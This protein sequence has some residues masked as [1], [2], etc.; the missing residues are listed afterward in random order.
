MP[1][2]S[3][4]RQRFALALVAVVVV[5]AVASAPH[6]ANAGISTTIVDIPRTIFQGIDRAAK[7]IAKAF[8]INGD[9]AFKNSAQIFTNRL[10]KEV[11]TQLA[12]VGP[13]QKP[14]FLTKPKSF[15]KTVTNA[16]AGDFIDSFSRGVTGETGPGLPLSGARGR[17]LISRLLRAQ[18]GSVINGVA[19]QCK[20]DCDKSFST[21]NIDIETFVAM[22]DSEFKEYTSASFRN[23]HEWNVIVISR[24]IDGPG[25]TASVAE[26]TPTDTVP[27]MNIDYATPYYGSTPPY[28]VVPGHKLSDTTTANDCLQAQRQAL[29]NEQAASSTEVQQCLSSC[30]ARGKAET[31]AVKGLTGTDFFEAF[32]TMDAQNAPAAL[33]NAL[34]NDKSDIGQFLNAAGTLT[35]VIQE[36]VQGEQTNL[37]PNNLPVTTRVSEEVKTPSQA[38]SQLFGIPY[39]GE[40]GQFTYTGTSVADILKGIASFINSPVGRALTNYFKSKCGLNPDVCK[41]PS[42]ARSTVGQ[43]VFGNGAPT[44]VAGAKL[45]YAGFGKPNIITGDPGRNEIS[46][47]EQLAGTGLIDA[48]FRQAIEETMTVQEAVDKNLIDKQKTFGFDKNGVEPADGY[49]YRSLQ[50]LRKYRVTPVGWELAARYNLNFDHRDLSLGYLLDRFSMCG[51]DDTHRVCARGAKAD[52]SCKLFSDGTNDCGQ[53]EN[54]VGVT[55]GASPYCGLIDPNWV[56]KAPQTYCKRQGAGEEIIAKEFVCDQNNVDKTTGLEIR[57]GQNCTTDRSDPSYATSCHDLDAPVCDPSVTNHDIGRWIIQRNTDTC[58]D[59]QSCIAENDDGTCQAFGYCVQERQQFKFDGTQCTAENNSC[60]T[61]TNPLG[62]D[63]AYLSNTLDGRNCSPDNAGCTEYCAAG[64]YDAETQTCNGYCS[65]DSTKSCTSSAQCGVGTCIKQT[66]NFTAKIQSCDKSQIGCHQYLRT[67]EGANI[68]ADGGFETWFPSTAPINGPASVDYGTGG[69]GWVKGAFSAISTRAVIASDPDVTANNKAALSI[70]GAPTDTLSQTVHTGSDLYER[71]FTFSIRAK[72]AADCTAR[73]S[74]EPV[75][76]QVDAPRVPSG[77]GPNLD[78]STQWETHAVTLN[79]PG[80]DVFTF[81]PGP[82]YDLKAMLTLGTCSSQQLV[83]DSAQLEESPGPTQFKDYGAS[84][85][86]NLNGQR[87]ACTTADVGCLKYTPVNGGEPVFGQVRNSNRCSPD[88]VGCGAYTLEPIT[89]QP[90]RSGGSVQIVVPRGQICTAADVG[91]EEYTNLDEV[92]RGGEGKEYFKAVKQCIKPSQLAHSPSIVGDNP[93]GE[94]FYTW[95]GDAD[96]GYVL[97]SYDLV[98]STRS[99]GSTTDGGPCVH[100]SVGTVTDNP[101]CQ[102]TDGVGGTIEAGSCDVAEVGKNPD[103]AEFYNAALT[104]YYRLRSRTISITDDCHPYRNTV[105]QTIPVRKDLVYYL[106]TKENISCSADVAGCRAYTGN[107]SGTTRRV[108]GDNFET[109][110]TANWSGGEATNAATTLNGHSMQVILAGPTSAAVTNDKLLT[111]QFYAGRSY[112]LS[113]TAA[114]TSVTNATV[115]AALG[116]LSGG[117]FTP[118]TTPSLTTTTFPGSVTTSWNTAI[119]PSGPEWHSYALGPLILTQDN[120]SAQLGIM[121]SGADA[122]VD[123]V[124][125]TEVN[126][127]FYLIDAS[128]PQCPISEVGCAAYRDPR[129]TTNY[130]TSFTRLCSEQVAGCEALIDTHNSTTPFATTDKADPPL[131]LGVTTPADDIVTLVNNPAAYCPTSAKGCEAVGQPGYGPD[132]ALLSYETKYVLNNPDRYSLDLCM[133]KEL[134]CQVYTTSDDG[135]A[136]FKDPGVRTCEFRSSTD[137]N[138]RWY[139]TNTS[140]PC[141]SVIPPYVG[142]PVGPSCA[143]HCINGPRDGKACTGTPGVDECPGGTCSAAPRCVGGSNDGNPCSG[144]I[145]ANECPGGGVCSSTASHTGQIYQSGKWVNGSCVTND[146]CREN[147]T[148]NTE[149]N[150]FYFAGSCPVEQN[151]CTEYRDP[152]DPIDC[153]AECPLSQSQGGSIDYLDGSCHFTRCQDGNRAGQNCQTDLDCADGTGPHSCV[154]SDGQPTTGLPGCRPYYYLRQ[155]LQ[156]PTGECNGVVD[157][158]VGCRPFNDTTNPNLNFRGK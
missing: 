106:S 47:T 52:Q 32:K 76:T 60:T 41:G 96:L 136:Y 38:A 102:D 118:F 101:R 88:N 64:N 59:A 67:I 138:G 154:G 18:A 4:R 21:S 61:Y 110:G 130:L 87:Q 109:N 122:Y 49:P 155:S 1:R 28:R 153:R 90:P 51:Q 53:D 63:V 23:E 127:H 19:N 140:I 152:T 117:T 124:V 141:P 16:A 14:L 128:V 156:N 147:V 3:H 74:L 57:P 15:F 134:W 97:R 35:A 151:G 121:V 44:G 123:N 82:V 37:N 112:I 36:R 34:S 2:P 120:P 7:R 42:N 54:G 25:G 148:D 68:L 142:R 137:G 80:T 55:C 17:F 43:I 69:V 65:T 5:F 108:F 45:L 83:I 6:P 143:P 145:G 66:I 62:Q 98:K 146:D 48:Q 107:A 39:V 40:N 50:Y 103:C 158:A 144:A 91:C 104:V 129:G 9:V 29:L 31:D 86:I 135:A 93:Y 79:V 20:D 27:C 84:G 72:A 10:L 33:A 26:K 85:V 125:L 73:L 46:I 113:F 157:T 95:V 94:T 111:N 58:A 77:T 81:T 114:S 126:D 116:R 99:D 119:T 133:V 100:L 30:Q 92:A 105:D 139:I 150:C 13:G 89:S 149:N 12:T 131:D 56:L 22:P 11:Q 71:S 78:V 132:Q 24:A 70:Q 75:T 115:T 8:K